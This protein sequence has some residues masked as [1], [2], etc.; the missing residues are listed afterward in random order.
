MVWKCRKKD[1]TK[2]HFTAQNSL[3]ILYKVK[4]R[5]SCKPHKCPKMLHF[6]Y[7]LTWFWGRTFYKLPQILSELS[8]NGNSSDMR[9]SWHAVFLRPSVRILSSVTCNCRTS[10]TSFIRSRSKPT[11]SSYLYS[12]MSWNGRRES[13]SPTFCLLLSLLINWC[14]WVHFCTSL[15]RCYKLFIIFF[16]F[17]FSRLLLVCSDRIFSDPKCV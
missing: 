11:L 17:T 4:I 7:I 8:W 1:N 13:R 3:Q 16:F 12:C 6:R 15:T 9:I 2:L 14:Y 5:F 10:A